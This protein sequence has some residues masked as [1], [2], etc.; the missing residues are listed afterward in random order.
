MASSRPVEALGLESRSG[1]LATV[2]AW[3][4]RIATI[5]VLPDDSDED[6][7]RKVSLT[8]LVSAITVLALA[9]VLIYA[10]LGL[11]DSAAIPL[12]FQFFTIG[13][14]AL[15]ARFGRF[16]LFRM[17]S[18]ALMLLLPFLLQVSLGGFHA[19][20][21]V[22]LWSLVSP[23][24]ALV[25]SPRPQP[26]FWTYLVFIAASGVLEPLLTPDP[27]P[28]SVNVAFVI[29]NF[30]AVS[31]VVYFLLRFFIRGLAREREKSELLLL[32]IL[33]API[34]R[35][36]KAGER[37][38]ADRVDDA[39][40]LFADLVDFTSLSEQLAP[41][42]VVALLD[43]LFSEFDSRVAARGLE[44]IKT[45]GDAYMVVGGLLEPRADAAEAVADL[46]LELREMIGG[47]RSSPGPALRLRIG[48]DIGP[49]VA[50][51]IGTRK[52]SYDLWGD[53]VN[54]ASRMESHGIPGEIQVSARAFERLKDGYGFQARGTVAVKG[55]GEIPT[56][57]LLGRSTNASEGQAAQP[58]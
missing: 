32:N 56:F 2:P 35:R 50:G 53:T 47:W 16:D 20:S 22:I 5:G 45:V 55:K 24:G 31:S 4:E 40:V 9:W 43:G 39:A 10:A 18:L 13:G 48:I 17:L 51:V 41:E 3:V 27:I 44:K 25:F 26:W 7:L 46:A 11:Y 58:R 8:L 28:S 34:A 38:L 49:V 54:T 42:D 37:R 36:L 52:F 29:L 15:M 14:L 33:P 21:G 1:W 30:G 12:G 19:S 23:L 57:L 6:Q